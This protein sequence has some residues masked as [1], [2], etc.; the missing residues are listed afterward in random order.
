MRA[1]G[2]LWS[3]LLLISLSACATTGG[4]GGGSDRNALTIEDLAQLPEVNTL[5]AI[6]RLRPSWIRGRSLV[7]PAAAAAGD[8]QTR[9]RIDGT[10]R[11]SL[12]D[13]EFL[14]IRDVQEIRFLSASDAT[15]LYG[16]G[17]ANGLIE[18]TTRRGGG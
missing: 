1:F 11:E 2:L 18:V 8:T 3:L 16:T 14:P 6:Q 17:F 7:T 4:A 15:T 12:A 10:F 13:L 9:L 5:E